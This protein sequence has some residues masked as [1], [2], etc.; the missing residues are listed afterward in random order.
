MD[1]RNDSVRPLSLL[2]AVLLAHLLTVLTQG[3]LAGMFLSG[4]DTAVA[5]HEI[6][7]RAVV[8]ICL[9]QI[10][11][12]IFLRARGWCPA[13]LLL[14]AIGILFAEVLETYTGYRRILVLHVPLAILIFGG[15][16][17]QLFWAVGTARLTKQASI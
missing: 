3:V 11:I 14:Y 12:T 2:R 1:S 7:G 10:V 4:N 16:M 5:L 8:G 9:L 6:T 17:R 15:I 13:W